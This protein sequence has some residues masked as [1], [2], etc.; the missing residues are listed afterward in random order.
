MTNNLRSLRL[1]SLLD[2]N[3][4]LLEGSRLHQLGEVGTGGGDPAEVAVA[5][6][7]ELPFWPGDR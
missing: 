5:A 1:D 6:S 4:D 7:G 3:A 2:A